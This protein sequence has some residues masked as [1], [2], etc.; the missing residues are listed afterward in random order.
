[1][2]G[3]RVSFFHGPCDTQH[4]SCELF[5][6]SPR[7][8]LHSFLVPGRLLGCQR[9]L[10]GHEPSGST[11][12]PT[13]CPD[14]GLHQRVGCLAERQTFENRPSLDRGTREGGLGPQTRVPVSALPDLGQVTSSL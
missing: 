14:L 11:V 4:L 7:L 6:G 1:M 13:P 3:A 5:R 8:S 12:Y 9:L 10:A 2:S